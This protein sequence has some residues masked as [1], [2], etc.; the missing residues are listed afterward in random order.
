MISMCGTCA[1]AGL[2][3]DQCMRGDCHD[4]CGDCRD[5]AVSVGTILSGV[6]KCKICN[7]QLNMDEVRRAEGDC[8]RCAEEGEMIA[9]GNG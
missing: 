1:E 8:D 3:E 5:T 2:T 9:L 4:G 7:R 6:V